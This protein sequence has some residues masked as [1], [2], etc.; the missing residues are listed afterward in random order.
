MP[1]S[2]VQ[3]VQEACGNLGLA[4]PN[5]AVSSTDF[6]IIQMLSLLN[7]EGSKLARR[8]EWQALTSE[9]TFTTVATVSQGTLT[10]IIGANARFRKIVDET[11]WNRTTGTIVLGP[12]PP[13]EWQ[14][15]LAITSAGPYAEYRI[16]GGSLLFDPVPT[17]G[18]S[19]YFEYVSYNWATLAD[20]SGPKS[21]FTLDDDLPLFDDE[22]LLA[23]L[24]WRWK[25]SKGLDFQQAFDDYE[26]LVLSMMSDDKTA[27]RIKLDNM[28]SSMRAPG[29]PYGSWNLTNLG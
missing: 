11:I 22:V 4:Q 12:I 20:G 26:D 16:R 19:C 9:A 7:E 10:S 28:L 5:T 8:F 21:R 3:I 24:K 29:V 17:A 27:R 2:C 1:R 25:E 23:G 15:R 13:E 18:E 14:G 6:Q